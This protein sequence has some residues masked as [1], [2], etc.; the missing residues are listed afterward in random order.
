MT[1]SNIKEAIGNFK[2][3]AQSL[4]AFIDLADKLEALGDIEAAEAE[5]GGRLSAKQRELDA[6]QE[7]I[8]ELNEQA[9]AIISAAKSE[10]DEAISNARSSAEKAVADAKVNASAIINDAR[11]KADASLANAQA[12]DERAVAAAEKVEAAQA[13]LDG[14]DAKIDEAR[15]KI[16][17]LLN[18]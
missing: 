13:E 2:A 7:R 16:N 9:G 15:A 17:A 14:L 1:A 18:G 12:A 6:L 11:E 10:A 5:I 8:G 4:R 3:S